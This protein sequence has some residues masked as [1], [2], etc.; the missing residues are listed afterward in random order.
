MKKLIFVFLLFLFMG[1]G[2]L[3]KNKQKNKEVTETFQNQKTDLQ[4]Q[5]DSSYFTFS[6]ESKI[7]DLTNLLSALNWKYEG[8]DS[9]EIEITHTPTGFKIKTKGTATAELNVNSESKTNKII[10]T[11]QKKTEASEKINLKVNS[12]SKTATKSKIINQEKKVNR[13]DFSVFLWIGLILIA[14]LTVYL[15]HR[16]NKNSISI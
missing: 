3:S 11:S 14:T 12:E 13:F 6:E 7:T 9:A 5:S 2:I 4:I 8:Q 15:W 16:K 10:E 1:C